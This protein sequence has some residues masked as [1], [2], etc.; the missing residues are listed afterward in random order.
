MKT[1]KK[2]E[3]KVVRK[4]ATYTWKQIKLAI[5][6]TYRFDSHNDEW[7]IPVIYNKAIYLSVQKRLKRIKRLK[8]I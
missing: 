2:Q 5:E 7:N 3:K 1:P 8:L 6:D 4:T